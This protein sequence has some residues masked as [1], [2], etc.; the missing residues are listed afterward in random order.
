MRINATHARFDRSK[1][2]HA[3]LLV[4]FLPQKINTKKNDGTQRA[5]A[6]QG[7]NLRRYLW[8]ELH[9]L[10]SPIRQNRKHGR[11]PGITHQG[12]R[13]LIKSKKPRF[14]SHRTFL[15]TREHYSWPSIHGRGNPGLEGGVGLPKGSGIRILAGRRILTWGYLCAIGIFTGS[16]GKS[17]IT[18][19]SGTAGGSGV[20][21]LA[22]GSSNWISSC[23]SIYT[24][25]ICAAS[26]SWYCRQ[27]QW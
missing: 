2:S 13:D 21:V 26:V 11:Q 14:T 3:R 25:F 20:T 16:L 19:G 23:V 24:I 10:H 9:L 15:T 18:G 7:K 4:I 8:R 1:F 5:P 22:I 17:G 27:S 6:L 12:S